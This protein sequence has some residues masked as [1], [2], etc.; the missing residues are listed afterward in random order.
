MYLIY[1]SAPS[2]AASTL[3]LAVV[4]AALVVVTVVLGRRDAAAFER[5]VLL[6]DEREIK[7]EVENAGTREERIV[8][9]CRVENA[10]SGPALNIES[11]VEIDRD[12][13]ELPVID[14]PP[15][16]SLSTGDAPRLFRWRS[17]PPGAPVPP[18]WRLVL[19]YGDLAGRRYRTTVEFTVGTNYSVSPRATQRVSSIQRWRPSA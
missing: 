8:L 19:V 10:G 15:L 2:L 1:A 17:Q 6:V 11:V 13:G 4:T 18:G 7:F 5:P 14:A 12:E 9:D 3:A 16:Q